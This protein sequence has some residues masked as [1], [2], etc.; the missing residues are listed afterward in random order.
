MLINHYNTVKCGERTQNVVQTSYSMI[1]L[2][3]FFKVS[4]ICRL[5][6]VWAFKIINCLENN[7]KKHQRYLQKKL[8]F[9]RI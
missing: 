2:F 1:F 4:R 5:L 3:C 9:R 8:N 7:N 6:D